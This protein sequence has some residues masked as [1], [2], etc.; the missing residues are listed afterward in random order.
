[1]KDLLTVGERLRYFA[2]EF[3]ASISEF[4][5]AMR[6]KSPGSLYDYFTNAKQPGIHF[7][8]RFQHL[9][10]NPYWLRYGSGTVFADNTAGRMLRA[11]FAE[12]PVHT[13]LE[14]PAGAL[15]TPASTAAH[16]PPEPALVQYRIQTDIPLAGIDEEEEIYLLMNR[17]FFKVKSRKRIAGEVLQMY[18]ATIDNI[19]DELRR[20]E[21]REEVMQRIA[22][23]SAWKKL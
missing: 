13:L 15:E 10:G 23:R 20:I 7:Q 16:A 6:Y 11:R 18:K 22:R 21:E 8:D 5:R 19:H 3:F 17:I 14:K 9:G 1:M 2:S 12:H 4:A